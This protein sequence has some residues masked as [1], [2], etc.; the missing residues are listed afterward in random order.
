VNNRLQIDGDFGDLR[1]E[2][3]HAFFH[4]A[5]ERRGNDD[6]SGHDAD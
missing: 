1:T 3:F 5:I 6:Y 2:G 4:D